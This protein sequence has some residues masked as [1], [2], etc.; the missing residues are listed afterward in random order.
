MVSALFAIVL[1]LGFLLTPLLITGALFSLAV[2]KI[3][4]HYAKGNT[5]WIFFYSVMIA[6]G[7]VV[8]L[9]WNGP[10]PI[11]VKNMVF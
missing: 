4:K 11:V 2:C 3:P 10:G 6:L 7:F 9:F 5:A 8:L 1:G